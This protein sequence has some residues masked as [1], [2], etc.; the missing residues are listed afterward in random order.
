MLATE[1]LPRLEGN[2]LSSTK[3]F[4]KNIECL[5][6]G[7]PILDFDST[8]YNLFLVWETTITVGTWRIIK[9]KIASYGQRHA[10]V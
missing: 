7:L 4:S 6:V 8:L 3:A 10:Y 5:Y 2:K 9:Y 1:L